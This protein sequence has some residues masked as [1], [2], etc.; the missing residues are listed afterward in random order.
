MNLRPAAFNLRPAA[1]L[2]AE[3]IAPR[4]S[5]VAAVYG[6]VN[7]ADRIA[8]LQCF[9]L[10]RSWQESLRVSPWARALQ[11]SQGLPSRFASLQ[12]F[13]RLAAVMTRQDYQ[14]LIDRVHGRAR[15]LATGGTSAAPFSKP[16][17][18]FLNREIH[19]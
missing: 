13:R 18:S 16:I 5:E 14:P 9:R 19:C 6:D 17:Y 4:L 15:W 11:A 1:W 7:E 10:N 12:D 3:R 8:A 2:M